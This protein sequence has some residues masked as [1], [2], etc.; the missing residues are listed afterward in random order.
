MTQYVMEIVQCWII[1]ILDF[2]I[3][4]VIFRYVLGYDLYK[5]RRMIL[6]GC[7]F[8]LIC[9]IIDPVLCSKYMTPIWVVRL[10]KLL[11]FLLPAFFFRGN[12]LKKVLLAGAIQLMIAN[13]NSI[14]QGMI[15]VWQEGY[16]ETL[17]L[18]LI[19]IITDIVVLFA[20]IVLSFFC[21]NNRK[22]IYDAICNENIILF[23]LL[24]F[25]LEASEL[26]YVH[27]TSKVP[28]H[29]TNYVYGKNMVRNG[30]VSIFSSF[31]FLAWFILRYQKRQLK[32]VIALNQ[33]CIEQQTIQ[34]QLMNKKDYDLKKFR[35]DYNAHITS[36]REL[37]KMKE[38]D[39]LNCYIKQMSETQDV[40]NSSVTTNH[41]IGD[42]VL[43]QYKELCQLE[44]I[45]FRSIGFFPS[46]L[47]L[48]ETDLCVLL[49][50]A[51]ENAYEAASKCTDN[52]F[53]EVQIKCFHDMLF[54]F[55]CN[56]TDKPITFKEGIP[57]T[58]KTNKEFH[59]FGTTNMLEVAK[60]NKGSVV[61]EN[62]G[63]G[64]VTTTITLFVQKRP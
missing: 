6:L 34:Y 60:R 39:K 3:G 43:N 4:L 47:S 41:I 48:K 61:W 22:K 35:H 58:A 29:I 23:F 16:V 17:D 64:I 24:F 10:N 32:M 2:A 28:E 7:F 26:F 21:R 15:Y 46:S 55:V 37:L 53:I 36:I 30:G 44:D 20:V 56:S 54:I 49:S 42:A 45:S 51:L 52:R 63:D 9:L 1:Y 33:R 8:F 31:L 62:K 12:W 40:V 57:T 59:G 50:N 38:Y 27:W 13:I 18:H 25:F 14:S 11:Y 5:N 19:G